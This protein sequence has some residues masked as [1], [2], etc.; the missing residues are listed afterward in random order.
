MSNAPTSIAEASEDTK[1][2]SISRHGAQWQWFAAA[3][4]V[5][6]GLALRL[7]KLNQE[8]VGV[9]EAF[10]MADRIAVINDGKILTVGTPEEIKESNAPG[11]RDFL[12]ATFKKTQEGEGR[13]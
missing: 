3:A 7:Y 4:V 2:V 6:A 9:D 10:S 11:V 1:T 13:S 8:S 12:Q 5:F